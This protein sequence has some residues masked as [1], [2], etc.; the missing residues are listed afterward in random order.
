MLNTLTKWISV[1]MNS[2]LSHT[3]RQDRV[4][5]RKANAVLTRMQEKSDGSLIINSAVDSSLGWDHLLFENMTKTI[6]ICSRKIHDSTNAVSFWVKFVPPL[7]S[8]S[9]HSP[10]VKNISTEEL[11]WVR[12]CL[13]HILGALRAQNRGIYANLVIQNRLPGE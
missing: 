3:F 2:A 10:L 7:D 12:H 1:S 11:L 8:P 13:C 9:V 5:P 4:H 6:N